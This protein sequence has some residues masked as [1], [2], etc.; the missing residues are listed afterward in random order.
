MKK[1]ET[2][3][4]EVFLRA[5]RTLPNVWFEKVQQ[6]GKRGTPDILACVNGRFVA[7]ELK[8]DA[9]AK[10]DRL[11]EHK[12]NLIAQSGGMSFVAYPDNFE[13][14]IGLIAIMAR[15]KK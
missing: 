9:K 7:I 8:K 13:T 1:D 12:L 4:K 15:G 2:K 6:V 10:V 14:V 5:L 3:F 11:Q